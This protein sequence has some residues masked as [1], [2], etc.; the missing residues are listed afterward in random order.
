M[1]K[2]IIVSTDDFSLEAVTRQMRETCPGAGAIANFVGVVRNRNDG[3]EV[4][5]LT[6]EHYPGMTEKSLSE[7]V[8]AAAKRW[9]LDAV[10]VHHRIGPMTVGEQIV[11]VAV[12]SPHRGEA[13]DACEYI[14]D[15]LKTEAPFWKKETTPEGERWVDA[16]ESDE[17]AKASWGDR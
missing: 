13:F 8:D 10:Y 1:Q 14:M 15:W 16:R 11:L 6:L 7:I 5:V 12:A 17:H 3:D 4:S 2:T 9:S